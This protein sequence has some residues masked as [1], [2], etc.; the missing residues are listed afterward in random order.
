M[1]SVFDG[2]RKQICGLAIEEVSNMSPINE[3][4]MER[5]GGGTGDRGL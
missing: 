1:K 5:G 4:E 2:I 3:Q